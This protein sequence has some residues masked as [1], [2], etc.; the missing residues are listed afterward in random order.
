MST[1]RNF[2][3]ISTFVSTNFSIEKMYD[4]ECNLNKYFNRNVSADTKIKC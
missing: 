2:K 4:I 1:F 3:T